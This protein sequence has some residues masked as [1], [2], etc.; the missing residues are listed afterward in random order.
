MWKIVIK[1]QGFGGVW[2]ESFCVSC[3]PVVTLTGVLVLLPPAAVLK[4]KGKE[5][6]LWQSQLQSLLYGLNSWVDQTCL[7]GE[8]YGS[9]RSPLWTCFN[10]FRVFIKVR[11]ITMIVKL[12]LRRQ[13]LQTGQLTAAGKQPTLVFSL[14]LTKMIQLVL[15]LLTEIEV[16]IYK[17]TAFCDVHVVE[18]R[19]NREKKQHWLIFAIARAQRRKGAT[20]KRQEW[21]KIQGDV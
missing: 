12:F 11:A 1:K 16:E 6:D 9:G 19:M 4:V 17:Q 2:W 20:E 5:P 3:I 15:W 18:G 14:C 8:G 7:L 13:P 21:K 10:M